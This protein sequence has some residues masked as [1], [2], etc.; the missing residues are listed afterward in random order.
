M[1][2]IILIILIVSTLTHCASYDFS[3]K[4]V[5]QGNL[6][7]Y[8]KIKR[9]HLGMHKAEAATLMGTSLLSPLFTHARW[10]YVYTYRKGNNALFVH[11]LILYFNGDVLTRIEQAPPA[12]Q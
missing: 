7:P 10:D 12:I 2:A 5:Q 8:D 9:L 4:V 3:R 11:R 6:L 1:K